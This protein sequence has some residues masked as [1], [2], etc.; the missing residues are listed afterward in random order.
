MARPFRMAGAHI[1]MAIRFP[2][3][4]VRVIGLPQSSASSTIRCTTTSRIL[5]STCDAAAI[6]LMTVSTTM[7]WPVS[8]LGQYALGFL[9][10]SSSRS[11]R[12]PT[13]WA[14]P[15]PQQG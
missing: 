5:P 3:P 10:G 6:S 2:G 4:V 13:L 14:A 11:L 8:H 1:A 12:L 9:D 15:G 7:S